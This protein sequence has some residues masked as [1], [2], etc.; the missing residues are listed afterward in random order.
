MKKTLFAIA[1][2]LLAGSAIATVQPPVVLPTGS[3]SGTATSSVT[4]GTTSFS[5]ANGVNQSA[6]HA[7]FATAE[8]CV[9]V[10]GVSAPG[11]NGAVVSTSAFTT[12]NTLTGGSGTGTGGTG[13]FA[14]QIGIGSVTSTAN[15]VGKH[16]VGEVNAN[17]N[18][19]TGTFSES[20]TLNSQAALSASEGTAKNL[21]VAY[22]GSNLLVGGV[23]TT[24]VGKTIGADSTKTF[25]VGN[26]VTNAGGL[27]NVGD[28]KNVGSFQNGS[29]DGN[30]TRTFNKPTVGIGGPG[31]C[32]TNCN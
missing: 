1:A 24:A 16:T 29:F 8:N 15:V 30:I 20:S 10:Q 5:V 19:A 4:G 26:G 13:S 25:G 6:K 21:T 17:S 11:T 23:T 22:V 32:T 28:V 14:T 27:L 2:T 12:G 18:V 3:V 31:G 9:V 7:S